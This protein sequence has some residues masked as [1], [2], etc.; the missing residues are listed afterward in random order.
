MPQSQSESLLRVSVTTNQWLLVRF[1]TTMNHSEG[2][3]GIRRHEEK[4]W[5]S[6]N[7]GVQPSNPQSRLNGFLVNSSSFKNV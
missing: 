1:N 3:S 2:N 7:K 5:D 4:H 6:D